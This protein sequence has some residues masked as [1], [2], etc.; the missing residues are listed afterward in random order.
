M[1]FSVTTD[2]IDKPRAGL[3]VVGVFQKRKLGTT[4]TALD[5]A[6]EGGIGNVLKAGE[7]DGEAGST[8]LIPA[9]AKGAA[10]TV[11]AGLGKPK[12]FAAGSARKACTAVAKLLAERP[13]ATVAIAAGDLLPTG[14]DIG[15]LIRTLVAGIGDAAYRF[16]DYKG[17]EEVKPIRLQRVIFCVAED[18]AVDAEKACIEAAA[19]LAGSNHT[20]DLGNTP[21]ND[22]YPETLAEAARALAKEHKKL[23]AT[24]LDEQELEKLG[25][26]A[27]LAVGRGSERPPRLIA[28]EYGGG[29][30][31]AAPIVLV[32]KGITFDTGGISLKPG[33][34]MD[35]MKYDM[36]GAATVLGVMKAVSQLK[37][38]LN[39]VGVITSA[40][41]MPD[42]RATRPGDIVKTLSGRTVEIL[43]TDAEGRLVLCDALTWVERFKPKAVIDI[44]TLTGA[45]IIA[46]GHQASAVLGNDEDLVAALK[47][48]G[49]SSHDRTWELPLWDEY[50][51]QLK[52]NFADMANIGGRPAGTITA[53]CFLARFAEKYPWA[54]LDIAGVA[55]KSGK[56]KGAT[57]RPVPLLM[58]YLLDQAAQ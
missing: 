7:M 53:A 23:E 52:S 16:N 10:G 45:C 8:L 6:L 42:G 11:L 44:A 57:G 15:W 27:I 21:P 56:E 51:E 2:P 24:V 1:Q 39:V 4:A 36:C 55:W 47:Q 48:A 50:Q 41:N 43:N 34:A 58:H 32:G 49:E 22:L 37:L 26:N 17:K 3:R 38:P 35:E 29:P 25:A 33:E 19:I 30:K 13:A 9:S 12:E 46:L 54:H 14:Q 40:E 20:R 28:L 18:Q 5:A 31:D